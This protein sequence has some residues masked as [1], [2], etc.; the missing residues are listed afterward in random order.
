M[1]SNLF[2]VLISIV[3][4][5]SCS[6]KPTSPKVNTPWQVETIATLWVLDSAKST[7]SGIDTFNVVADN[8]GYTMILNTDG[9]IE[10]NSRKTKNT[11]VTS[12]GFNSDTTGL[13]LKNGQAADTAKILKLEMGVLKIQLRL[14]KS[15][16]ES[17]VD[18]KF[19]S[20]VI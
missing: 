8:F 9:S 2:I 20:A 11:E 14:D 4:L 7:Y 13:I 3:L 17:L 15:K 19:F 1:K 12:W 6:D 5:N 10:I 16:E 18:L